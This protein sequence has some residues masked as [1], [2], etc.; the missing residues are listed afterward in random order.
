MLLQMKRR[1]V[2]VPV[3]ACAAAAAVA[4]AVALY[5]YD[6]MASEPA[7]SKD[8]AKSVAS[9]L[10]KHG[11]LADDAEL[12]TSGNGFGSLEHPLAASSAAIG[13]WKYEVRDCSPEEGFYG[14]DHLHATSNPLIS[15]HVCG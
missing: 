10:P 1:P 11:P 2:S 8:Q 4:G 3:V 9:L 13:G 12:L 6:P 15:P 14:Q 7:H 5:G